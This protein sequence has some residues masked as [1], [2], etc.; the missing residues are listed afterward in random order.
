MMEVGGLDDFLQIDEHRIGILIADVK[1]TSSSGAHK[2]YG[3]NR[4]LHVT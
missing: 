4:F 1:G 2:L 3:Q